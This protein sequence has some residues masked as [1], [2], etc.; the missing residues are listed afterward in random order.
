MKQNNGV[1][2]IEHNIWVGRI[3]RETK[4]GRIW[5]EKLEMVSEVKDRTNWRV[6]SQILI[7]RNRDRNHGPRS[8]V[9]H[10]RRN[11]ERTRGRRLKSIDKI[12]VRRDEET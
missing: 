9:P 10:E 5:V 7:H 4:D 2:F 6:H 1:T 12:Q 8:H 3:S 11:S